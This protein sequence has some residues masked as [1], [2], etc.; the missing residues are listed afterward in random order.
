MLGASQMG[1][2][3]SKSQVNSDLDSDL[4]FLTKNKVKCNYLW[5]GYLKMILPTGKRNWT[6]EGST[7]GYNNRG[8]CGLYSCYYLP[9][10]TQTV[11]H[12]PTMQETWVRSL[13]REDPLEKEMAPHSSILA[14]KIPWTEEPGRLQS[15][16]SQRVGHNWATSLSHLKGE[17]SFGWPCSLLT[18][19]VPLLLVSCPLPFYRIETEAHLVHS[20]SFPSGMFH[21]TFPLPRHKIM[22]QGS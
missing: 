12:V 22:F 21:H 19:K 11:K 13:G 3:F 2:L 1:C 9:H 10:L 6:Y 20:I 17:A 15:M 7:W 16:G 8:E 5:Y 14:W 4:K 18:R